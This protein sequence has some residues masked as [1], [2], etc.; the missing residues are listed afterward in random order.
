LTVSASKSALLLSSCLRWAW[1]GAKE[2]EDEFADT[3]KR[4]KGTDF[5]TGMDV[6]YRI[7]AGLTASWKPR[8]DEVGQWVNLAKE[9][10]K[11]HLEP[12]CEHIFTEVYVGFNFSTG[13]SH[14]DA[15]V[16]DRQYPKMPGFLPGTADLVCVLADGSLLVADWKTGGGTGADK[17]LLTLSLG[18]RD[19]LRTAD[20]Q[21]RPV[22][23]CILY[24]GDDG[25]H[26]VEWA[27]SDDELLA[28]RF[29]M[30]FQLADVGVRKDAVPGIHCTQLY[31]PHLA[32]CPGI[33]STVEEASESPEGL[34]PAQ[35]LVRRYSISEEPSSPAHAGAIMERVTAAKRQMDFYEKRVRSYCENGGRCTAGGFE[36]S[37]GRDGFRWRPIK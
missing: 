19:R 13:E 9:W 29:A 27:V 17:Q 22:R 3:T 12:R 28:H 33:S 14:V 32:Y 15:A 16:R 26:P 21:L 30:Q 7:L 25:V 11:K 34:L 1:D 4:D 5:H 31:C 24:V 2:Y 10:S 23:L 8:W 6:Y 35:S 20:G 36:F 18:L 37:K